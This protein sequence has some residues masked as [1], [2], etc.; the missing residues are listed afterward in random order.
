MSTQNTICRCRKCKNEL[1]KKIINNGYTL[2]CPKCKD[3]NRG[4]ITVR[5]DAKIK[6]NG[7]II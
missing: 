3:E 2:T 7:K 1:V 4:S 6:V 5:G